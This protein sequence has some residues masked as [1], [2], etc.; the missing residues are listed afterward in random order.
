MNKDSRENTNFLLSV[1]PEDLSFEE[2]RDGLLELYSS[3]HDL[4]FQLGLGPDGFQGTNYAEWRTKAAYKKSRIDTM[5]RR[6]S[7][8]LNT[9]KEESELNYLK[10]AVEQFLLDTEDVSRRQVLEDLI[11]D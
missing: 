10:Y 6:L 3:S 5:I 2:C 4:S 7:F 9:L 1:N 11:N 8:R